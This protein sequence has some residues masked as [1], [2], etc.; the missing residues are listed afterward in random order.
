LVLFTSARDQYSSIA[1]VEE[2]VEIKKLYLNAV[3]EQE[4]SIRFC[5][6]AGTHDVDKLMEIKAL[7]GDSL[8]D[9]LEVCEKIKLIL[10]CDLKYAKLGQ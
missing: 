3:K 7:A 1:A 5:S 9:S 8:T 4:P 10:D 6:M 2:S